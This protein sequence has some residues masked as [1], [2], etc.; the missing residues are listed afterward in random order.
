MTAQPSKLP[1]VKT[2]TLIRLRAQEARA[3][4]ADLR[5]PSASAGKKNILIF[6]QGRS[7]STLLEHLLISTGYFTGHHEALNT[8]TREVYWPSRFIR[9]LGRTKAGGNVIVHVKPE[10]L[11]QSRPKLGPVDPRLF[12]DTLVADGW[13]VIHLQRQD[14]LRQMVSKYVAKAR[15]GFHKTDDKVENIRLSLSEDEFIAD[16]E[17]RIGWLDAEKALFEG[18]PHHQIL[19]EEHLEQPDRH[20][21]TIDALLGTLGLSP[22]PVSTQLRK[23]NATSPAELLANGAQLRAAFLARGWEWTL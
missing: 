13:M 21:P 19:Y 1:F 8:V 7:G 22:R 18:V 14:V 12:L 4:L 15:G 20:Q 6:G 2:R 9:G 3:Y 10:H 5:G 17:R 16:Y 11:G 23:I